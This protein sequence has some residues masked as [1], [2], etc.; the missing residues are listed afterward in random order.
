LLALLKASALPGTERPGEE[1]E[2]V[3]TPE[4]GPVDDITRRAK[5]AALNRITGIGIEGPGYFGLFAGVEQR[6]AIDAL[7][8]GDRGQG[9]VVGNVSFLRS[10]RA[11]NGV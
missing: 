3:L 10:Y 4:N 9:G 1:I 11:Q 2:P 6:R 5:H 8:G 7:F